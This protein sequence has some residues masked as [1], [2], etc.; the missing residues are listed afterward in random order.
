MKQHQ[1]A[2]QK[3]ALI[4]GG[5]SGMGRAAAEELLRQG[6]N[7]H[8]ADLSISACNAWINMLEANTDQAKAYPVDVSSSASV[9]ALFTALKQDIE[10]LDVMV[11]AAAILGGIFL[12]ADR[13]PQVDFV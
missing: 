2:G 5:G 9:T 11:H 1:T 7:V 3:N 12:R 13:A 10:R 6:F 8:I 4:I